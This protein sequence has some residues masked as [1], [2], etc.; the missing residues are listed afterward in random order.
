MP[1]QRQEMPNP[2]KFARDI[3]HPTKTQVMDILKGAGTHEYLLELINTVKDLGIKTLGPVAFFA[4]GYKLERSGPQANLEEV[5]ASF[6]ILRCAC[7]EAGM[8]PQELCSALETVK[9]V[10]DDNRLVDATCILPQYVGTKLMASG[11]DA[12]QFHIVNDY[13]WQGWLCLQLR[14]L[15][16]RQKRT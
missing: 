9:Y 15:L 10:G 13:Q 3:W 16:K 2:E 6:P 7:G 14:W 12:F 8:T 5:F 4:E 11:T 1:P